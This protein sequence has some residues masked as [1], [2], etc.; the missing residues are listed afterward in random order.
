M[1]NTFEGE[2]RTVLLQEY[3]FEK[4]ITRTE[5]SDKDLSLIK[6][7]VDDTQ[8]KKH[9]TNIQTKRQNDKLKHALEKYPSV[10][11]PDSAATAMLKKNYADTSLL[12]A[13]PDV[14]KDQQLLIKEVLEM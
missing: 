11:H 7:A 13:L 14:N 4:A 9:I 5:I 10:K 3:G 12:T 8:L 2:L 1:K 6:S